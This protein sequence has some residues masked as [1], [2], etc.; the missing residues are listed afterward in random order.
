MVKEIKS[1]GV[2][3]SDALRRLES[4]GVNLKNYSAL[5]FRIDPEND[6]GIR[7]ELS[8]RS[9]LADLPEF[10]RR[11]YLLSGAG[12]TQGHKFDILVVPKDCPRLDQREHE[13]GHIWNPEETHVVVVRNNASGEEVMW[14]A[15]DKDP[16]VAGRIGR[17]MVC[18]EKGWKGRE[19][20][21]IAIQKVS[22]DDFEQQAKSLLVQGY[23]LPGFFLRFSDMQEFFNQLTQSR[24]QSSNL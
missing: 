20:D 1:D 21:V 3:K 10:D 12:D 16:K 17:S 15:L 5:Y 4:S 23:R 8:A 9:S 11:A 24:K 2:H 22:T 18:A 13:T 6:S 14:T 7:R 19:V